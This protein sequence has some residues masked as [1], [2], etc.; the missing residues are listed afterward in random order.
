MKWDGHYGLRSPFVKRIGPDLR[1]HQGWCAIFLHECCSCGDEG[2]GGGRGRRR[3]PRN[4]DGGT[5]IKAPVKRAKEM[6]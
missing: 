6:A 2:G 1:V 4:D 3:G 5:K